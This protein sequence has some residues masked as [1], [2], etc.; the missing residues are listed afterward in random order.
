MSLIKQ[1]RKQ[2]QGIRFLKK[3]LS[4]FLQIKK[5]L[6]YSASNFPE[7]AGEPKSQ[8]LSEANSEASVSAYNRTDDQKVK[9]TL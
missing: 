7:C 8:R 9:V 5:L 3:V 6:L 2:V 1:K 4:S